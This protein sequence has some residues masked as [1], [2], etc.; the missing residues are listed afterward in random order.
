MNLSLLLK[1]LPLVLITLAFCAACGD[2]SPSD[3]TKLNA[4]EADE[5]AALCEEVC[6]DAVSYE[7]SC[8]EN[9][10]TVE[11]SASYGDNATTCL[12]GCTTLLEV[13]DACEL[14][15]GEFRQIYTET[16]TCATI[17]TTTALTFEL[18]ACTQ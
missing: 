5:R 18:L 12:S 1:R 15:A 17:E 6:D 3:D 13:N 8:E 11:T 7:L 16:P 2:D 14:N 10:V 4:L 9:G